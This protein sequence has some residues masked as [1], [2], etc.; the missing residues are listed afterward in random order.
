MLA[1]SGRPFRVKVI[2][3][4]LVTT[5]VALVIST[6]ALLAYDIENY[7]T[8]LVSDARTQAEILAR[9]NAPALTFDDA[10]AANANLA[11][12]SFR[13]NFVAAA[14]YDSNGNVFSSYSRDG[15]PLTLPSLDTVQPLQI[16][17]DRLEL[18]LPIVENGNLL[19]TVFLRATYGL[20]GRILD[21]SLI[22]ATVMLLSLVVA[23]ALSLLL[24]PTVTKPVLAVA[25]VARR[26][27]EERD[28]TL[29]A[30][31]KTDDEIGTLVTTFNAMLDEV[32][33]HASALRS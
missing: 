32:D 7:R 9:A 5:F 3:V 33:A 22:L 27:I 16:Y 10:D 26:V 8:F 30:E 13:R 2:A 14:I 19:G 21:Y 15:I 29:R 6:A 28:F 24:A 4:V 20:A 25:A 18:V 17:D 11:I 31:T 12:L 1:L 23:F